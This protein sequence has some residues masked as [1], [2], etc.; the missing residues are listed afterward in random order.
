M[1]MGELYSWGSCKNGILGNGET[2]DDQIS[3]VK[4]VLHD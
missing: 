1:E 2:Q 4:V 3:P